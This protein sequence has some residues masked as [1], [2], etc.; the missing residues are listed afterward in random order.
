MDFVAWFIVAVTTVAECDVS[1]APDKTVP[2]DLGEFVL[3]CR[4]GEC[5]DSEQC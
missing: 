4:L 2:Q 5:C 1:P 3:I